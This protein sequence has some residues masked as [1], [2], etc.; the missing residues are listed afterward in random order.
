MH[1][2]EAGELVERVRYSAYGVPTGFPAGDTNS[3]GDWDASDSTD[4]GSNY[5]P[6]SSY[7]VLRD[8]DLD[9][10]VDAADVTHAN[11]ITG[12][13]QTL[14]RDILTSAAVGNRIGYAGYQYDPTFNGLDRHLSHVR[15]RVYDAEAGRWTRRDGEVARAANHQALYAAAGNSPVTLRSPN[16]KASWID[17]SPLPD[18]ECKDILYA[19]L[20]VGAAHAMGISL[21]P[22]FWWHGNHCGPGFGSDY[23]WDCPGMPPDDGK[24]T[25]G[26]FDWGRKKD[27]SCPITGCTDRCCQRHDECF[28]ESCT[29]FNWPGSKTCRQK[30]CDASMCKC[31]ADCRYFGM[32]P[33]VFIRNMDMAALFCPGNDGAP[34]NKF[35]WEKCDPPSPPWTPPPPPPPLDAW[36]P[37]DGCYPGEDCEPGYGWF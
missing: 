13:Y 6:G 20:M 8:A 16:G 32:C 12:G 2:S 28:F 33:I 23:V 34:D 17:A 29:N 27:G 7:A 1:R 5:T 4:I 25:C 31:L 3:D 15:H 10:D 26:P 11:S 24:Q 37:P 19:S 22:D 35:E 21:V 30:V 14:G 9:G 36:I 18:S